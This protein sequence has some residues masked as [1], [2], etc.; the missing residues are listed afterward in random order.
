M[1]FLHRLAY[2]LPQHFWQVFLA[3]LLGVVAV[4][5]WMSWKGWRDDGWL[6]GDGEAPHGR[7]PSRWL[8]VCFGT[9]V[10]AYVAF[11]LWAEDFAYKDGHSFTEFSA[12]GRSRPPAIWPDSGRFWPL[13]YQEYNLIARL[14]PTATAYLLYGAAQLV[15][16]L[17][18]LYLALW[19]ERPALRLLLF[20]VLML[21][22]AFGAVF[23]ELTYADRNVVFAICVLVFAV[24]RHERRPGWWWLAL[25]IGV[26]Y[27]A[28]YF[29][30]TSVA[31]LAGFAA[32]RLLL[33]ASRRGFRRALLSPCEIG[34][35]LACACFALELG[36]TLLPAGRS[37]YVGE[38][39]VGG[40]T[41]TRR[42]LMA[43]PLT[44]AFLVAFGFHVV[45]TWRT[46][47]LFSPL[48]DSLAAGAVLHFVMLAST[49]VVETYLM[50]PTE[51]VA[52]V[53]L[54]R[55]TSRWWEERPRARPVLASLGAVTLAASLAF[56]TFRLVQRKTVV[57]QTQKI[58]DFVVSYYQTPGARHTRLYLPA[59]DGVVVNFVSF[60]DYR[61]L[62]F[63]R[64]G[65]PLGTEAIEV[66]GLAS[67]EAG[68]CV[69]Y[70]NFACR[71]DLPRVG[72]LLVRL[73]EESWSAVP[74]A[75]GKLE[76]E[77]G[78]DQ[79]RLEVLYVAS[80][81]GPS[82]PLRPLLAALYWLSP[83]LTGL[84]PHQSLPDTWLRVSASRVE[85]RPS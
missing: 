83:T 55:L 10:A 54:L 5:L 6:V 77:L 8:L 36:L 69:G 26:S 27:C 23:A 75:P 14:S 15:V 47:R 46:G 3:G 30:E 31:L 68:L 42:Y 70:A 66:A 71:R 41:A 49:G 82:T 2:A 51:L 13:G 9:F 25:A 20:V 12:I 21:A 64:Q 45:Q 61:G 62:R 60:L 74:A 1:S 28:L 73:P 43:E 17:W 57:W 65:E 33:H 44:S 50:G 34:I 53:T 18:L 80:P 40:L 85:P 11:M 4:P 38:L 48:W 56:G 67:F 32:T 7:S 58:A 52:G 39:S 59:E 24:D 22:P 72:D 78:L 79:A 16:G 63:H 29:K 37:A 76:A 19:R 84:F 81:L 35:L